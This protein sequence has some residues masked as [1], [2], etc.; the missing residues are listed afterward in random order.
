MADLA[1]IVPVQLITSGTDCRSI[2]AP[3]C[4][5]QR[6]NV[7]LIGR[8]SVIITPEA[9]TCPALLSTIV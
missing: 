7:V 3:L 1:E 4:V 9:S 8:V 5:A 6:R 2:P